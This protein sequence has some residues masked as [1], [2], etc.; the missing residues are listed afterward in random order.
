MFNK[1]CVI[2]GETTKW[3]LWYP[4]YSELYIAIA[5]TWVTTCFPRYVHNII[6]SPSANSVRLSGFKSLDPQ[7]RKRTKTQAANEIMTCNNIH[8]Y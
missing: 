1:I 7:E 5:V 6:L 2:Q 3:L 8:R 4:F